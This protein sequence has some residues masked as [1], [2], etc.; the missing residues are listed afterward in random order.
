MEDIIRRNAEYLEIE[1]DVVAV[2]NY[3]SIHI[4]TESR[5]KQH[6]MEVKSRVGRIQAFLGLILTEFDRSTYNDLK[7]S[8]PEHSAYIADRL[9]EEERECG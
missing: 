4:N 1:L 5:Q 7:A 6:I 3:F 8:I 9:E 2:E